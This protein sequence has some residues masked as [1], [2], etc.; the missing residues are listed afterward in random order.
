[1]PLPRNRP[2]VPVHV[3]GDGAG[4]AEDLRPGGGLRAKRRILSVIDSLGAGGGGAERLLLTTCGHLDR[5]RFEPAV[6]T[7]F[8]PNPGAADFRRLQVP[9][10]ELG[11][12]GARDLPRGI[13]RL[14]RLIRREGFVVVHT[15]LYYAN[16]AGRLASWGRAGVISTLHNPDY[17]YE[18]PGTWRFRAKKLLDR[19]TGR[20]INRILLA[21]SE[22][23]RRDFERH[24]GFSGIRVFPNYIDVETLQGRLE[25]LD[26]QALR[27]E[28]GLG[29]RAVVVL[30]V[31]RL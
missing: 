9:V 11:L 27:E 1:M 8:G 2:R 25:G 3:G 18:D 26:R 10:Y 29:P 16:V 15:H 7:L 19:L 6:A 30:H 20:W 21:V 12:G 5:G 17:T 31:G 24:L 23:V 13:L 28:L 4:N 22:D 14:R